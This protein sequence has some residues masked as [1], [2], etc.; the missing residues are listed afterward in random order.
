[1][2]QPG[3][4]YNQPATPT[5]PAKRSNATGILIAIGVGSFLGVV[6]VCGGA[7]AM[8]G[9]AWNEMMQQMMLAGGGGGYVVN[10]NHTMTAPSQVTAG[11]P[12]TVDVTAHNTDPYAAKQLYSV[13]IYSDLAQ[14]GGLKSV[15]PQPVSQTDTG[16]SV[17]LVFEH[18]VPS[19]TQ[20]DIQLEFE[21]PQQTQ[22]Y[23]LNIDTNWGQQGLDGYVEQY[24]DVDV[25]AG[26]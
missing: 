5:P 6:V 14:N 9:L 7:A 13:E 25:V 2:T 1:M 11:Q 22:L 10:A 26:P 19:N 16:Y 17:Q 15:T 12:F 24:Q 4:P 21:A 20:F 18:D 3:N 8:V 23:P